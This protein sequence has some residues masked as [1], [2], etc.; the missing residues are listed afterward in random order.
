MAP[1]SKLACCA[2]HLQAP[3][4]AFTEW[5]SEALSNWD[6]G[7]RSTLHVLPQ[8]N[9][10]RG[11]GQVQQLEASAEGPPAA[12]LLPQ[13]TATTCNIDQPKYVDNTDPVDDVHAEQHQLSNVEQESN[14]DD[15]SND[16]LHA[17][18]Q[19]SHLEEDASQDDESNNDDDYDDYLFIYL[20]YGLYTR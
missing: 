11:G 7:A 5:K 1:H 10:V 19:S 3:D 4:V 16:D 17:D 14:Q 12:D 6:G 20:L 13:E 9:P 18:R 8:D 2:I 15:E